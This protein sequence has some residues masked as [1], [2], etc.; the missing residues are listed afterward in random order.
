MSD[1]FSAVCHNY[2]PEFYT[3]RLCGKK[4]EQPRRYVSGPNFLSAGTGNQ[5]MKFCGKPATV[6]F[7]DHHFSGNDLR[8]S[9]DGARNGANL[10]KI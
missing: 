9:S 2:I 4:I 1:P 3:G 5:V 8:K 6:F 7:G 10:Q